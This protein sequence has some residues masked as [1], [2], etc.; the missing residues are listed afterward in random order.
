MVAYTALAMTGKWA[1][2]SGWGLVVVVLIASRSTLGVTQPITIVP[3][4]SPKLPRDPSK[5]WDGFYSRID[6]DSDRWQ[7]NA[8]LVETVRGREPGRALDVGAGQ[9]RNALHLAERGW[10]VT[11]LDISRVGIQLIDRQAR[12]RGLEVDTRRV[13]ARHFELGIECWDLIVCSYMHTVCVARA[14]ELVASLAPEGLLV[15]EGFERS[16]EVA[17]IGD[18]RLGFE[19]GVLPDAFSS[20]E[21]LQYEQVLARADWFA[22]HDLP[23]VRFV[24][25]KQ[26]I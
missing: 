19:P 20:L 5:R 21:V 1:T 24:A 17:G 26:R 11:A 25:R 23:I 14:D 12:A 10:R 9:G 6:L 4:S 8:L 3:T 15:V 13:D 2:R 22:E 18:G 16:E 7:P